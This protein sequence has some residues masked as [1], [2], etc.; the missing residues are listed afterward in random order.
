LNAGDF[1][2]KAGGKPARVQSSA[3]IGVEAAAPAAFDHVV[4]S[5]VVHEVPAGRL[6]VLLFQR[7]LANHHARGLL[8]MIE[9]SRDLVRGLGPSD[10]VAILTFDTSLKIWT[11]FS[12]VAPLHAP[13]PLSESPSVIA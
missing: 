7:S 9:E 13:S 2:V 3:W 5:S 11:E 4:A 6:I 12:P 10:S 1:T 8:R